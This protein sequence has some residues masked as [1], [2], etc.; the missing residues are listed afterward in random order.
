MFKKYSLQTCWARWKPWKPIFWSWDIFFFFS[1]LFLLVWSGLTE[2]HWKKLIWHSAVRQPGLNIK[3]QSD[4]RSYY[5]Y[6]IWSNHT[7]TQ[8]LWSRFSE[9]L[10]VCLHLSCF[11]WIKATLVHLHL[12]NE[13]TGQMQMVYL[14]RCERNLAIGSSSFTPFLQQVTVTEFD[15]HISHDPKWTINRREFVLTEQ[16]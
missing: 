12:P 4:E 8:S 16:L 3:S 6:H 15:L 11:A 7:H 13:C 10:R 9:F 14:A 2:L 1:V 5:F